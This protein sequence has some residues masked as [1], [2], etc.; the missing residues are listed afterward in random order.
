M[1]ISLTS[2]SKTSHQIHIID[3]DHVSKLPAHLKTYTENALELK[4]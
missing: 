4:K 3:K 1:Y 2:K